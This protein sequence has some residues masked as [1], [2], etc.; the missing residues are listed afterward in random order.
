MQAIILAGGRGERMGEITKVIPKSLLPLPGGS[1]L[2]YQLHL[3]QKLPISSIYV[4]TRHLSEEIK[5][6]FKNYEIGFI[7]QEKPLTVLSAILSSQRYVKERFLVLH[8]DNYISHDISYLTKS[9]EDNVLLGNGLDT[10]CYILDPKIFHLIKGIIYKNQEAGLQDLFKIIFKKI[11]FVEIKG[12]RK[13]I[14]TPQDLLDV[15]FE[16]L[17]DWS[18]NFHL[19]SESGYYSKSCLS[20]RH[21]NSKIIDS[22]IGPF[23]TISENVQIISSRVSYSVILPNSRI[24]EKEVEN[25]IVI[26]DNLFQV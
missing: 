6:G 16:I 23:V 20:W 2:E 19:N 12:W 3:L 24:I 18:G 17:R 4:V 10:G 9:D 22:N 11:R 13:N 26:G 7:H 1:I 14:N 8:G 15:N 25:S 5:K 21:K